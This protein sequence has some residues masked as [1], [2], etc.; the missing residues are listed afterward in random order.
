M[1]TTKAIMLSLIISLLFAYHSN[2]QDINYKELKN[3]DVIEFN[4]L[5]ALESPIDGVRVT[6]AYY[7]GE[8]ESKNAVIA[9]IDMLHNDECQG[10]RIVAAFSLLKIG[11]PTGIQEVRKVKQFNLKVSAD[12]VDCLRILAGLWD[13][14]L[15]NNPKEAVALRNIKLNYE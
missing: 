10:G 2:A 15:N 9:L 14:Y 12:T 7:L 8:M 4:Y 3:Y 5:K 11:D 13:L 1:K 6:S